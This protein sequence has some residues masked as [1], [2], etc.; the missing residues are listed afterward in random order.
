MV[1]S[2]EGLANP[3]QCVNDLLERGYGL[4]NFIIPNLVERVFSGWT[5][6]AGE[7]QVYKNCWTADKNNP[8]PDE[9]YI[10]RSGEQKGGGVYDH[11]EFFHYRPTLRTKFK[12]LGVDYQ[13]YYDWLIDLDDLFRCCCESL[14]LIGAVLDD[15]LP[16]YDFVS[17]ISRAYLADQPV[18]RLLHYCEAQAANQEIA[19]F[20][21]DRSL[22]TIHVAE[23]HPGLMLQPNSE[24]IPY[25]PEEG[26]ALVFPGRKAEALT[27]GKL[28]ALNHGVVVPN[29]EDVLGQQRQSIVFFGHI[30]WDLSV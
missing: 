30:V 4:T 15:R 2:L 20:H 11:K 1:A 5:K 26:K 18:L 21:A 19:K 16:G 22:L 12:V 27:E 14:E 28:R 25:L 9:G 3:A 17:R 24:R 8:D 13:G 10:R 7:D 23:T 6:F 29:D